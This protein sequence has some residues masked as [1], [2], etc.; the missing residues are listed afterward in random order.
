[1]RTSTGIEPLTWAEHGGRLREACLQYGISREYWLDLSSGINP[2]PWPL[3]ELP[4]SLWA[5]LPEEKDGLEEAARL[6][7]FSEHL[8]PV[9]GSQ[10][11]IRAL[12]WLRDPSRVGV[13]DPGYAEHALAW[14]RGGHRVIPVEA[15]RIASKLPELDV[16]VLIHPNNPTGV[17]FERETLLGWLD[18]LAARGGWLIVDEAFM[19]PTP[20]NSLCPESPRRGLIVLRSFGKFFGLAGARL[21]F[22]CATPGL[23]VRLRSHLGPW[24]VNAPA[25][26]IARQALQDRVW[27]AATR[28]RFELK[29]QRL[30]RLLTVHGLR[31]DGGCALFQWLRTPRAAFVHEQLARRGIL[32]RIFDQPSGLRFGLPGGEAEWNRLEQA[33]TEIGSLP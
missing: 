9:A 32:T 30:A 21:G 24:T 31:P 18:Q 4:T 29:A 17:V 1:M 15:E 20:E 13:L 8:L 25:R 23:L 33:L 10:A 27:Q 2:E 28:E 12:P 6:Y 3:P 26:W 7:Y 19:D 16:L 11:A 5:R 14:R 22:V